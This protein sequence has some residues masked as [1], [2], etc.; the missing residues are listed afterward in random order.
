GGFAGSNSYLTVFPLISFP[1]LSVGMSSRDDANDL[2]IFVFPIDVCHQKQDVS[3]H[4]TKA[5]PTVFPVLDP[6]LLHERPGIVESVP[7]EFKADAML[8]QIACGFRCVPSKR[9]VFP[10]HYENVVTHDCA[11]NWKYRP[12]HQL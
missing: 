4:D 10:R 6:V 11:V 9:N 1:F 7:C 12:P 3:G 2:Q 5:L 8:P